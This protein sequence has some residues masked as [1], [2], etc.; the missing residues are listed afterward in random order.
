LRNNNQGLSG[1]FPKPFVESGDGGLD[2]ATLVQP[3]GAVRDRLDLWQ[4]HLNF[5]PLPQ[6]QGA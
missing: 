6:G 2:L 4:H 3:L 1:V 5:S